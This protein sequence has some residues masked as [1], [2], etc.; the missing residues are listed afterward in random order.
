MIEATPFDLVSIAHQAVRNLWDDR[1][2]FQEVDKSSENPG[3]D[4]AWNTW[5]TKAFEDGNFAIQQIARAL[6]E[7]HQMYNL[8]VDPRNL[9]A[10]SFGDDTND[11]A[12]RG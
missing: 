8:T 9:T 2:R 5:R 3:R 1:S 11:L 4:E 12:G 7:F 10:R 6:V